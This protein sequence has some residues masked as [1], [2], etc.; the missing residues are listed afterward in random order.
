MG[1]A[2]LRGD[3]PADADEP[4]GAVLGVLDGRLA[5]CSG[6][7]RG[8]HRRSDHR[9]GAARLS[10]GGRCGLQGVRPWWWPRNTPTS[11][12]IHMR[13]WVALPGVGDYT[14]SAVL[15]FAFGERV[16][17]IDTN[18]PPRAEPG[19]PRCG[20]ARGRG[21]PRRAR[22]SLVRAARGDAGAG[23][24]GF[25]GDMEPGGLW[26]WEPRS[27]RPR[28]RSAA[29]ARCGASARSW[30]RGFPGW[31]SGAPGRANGSRARTV[32]CGALS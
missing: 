11:C 26:S 4:C 14:A 20:V 8:L 10:R 13:S 18:I 16:A 31:G 25:V 2:G 15:S 30:Q 12:P 28:R 17:V 29:T 21:L 7:R 1:R 19:L 22:I 27:V 6:A 32:R 23:C 24:F 5:G 9:L 3:E